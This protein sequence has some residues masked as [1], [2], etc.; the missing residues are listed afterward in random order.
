MAGTM[1]LALPA[2]SRT[3]A[4]WDPNEGARVVIGDR[5]DVA[6]Y[7]SIS[8]LGQGHET[9]MAQICA[10]ALGVPMEWITIFHGNTD[11]TPFGWGTFA[12]RGTVM[13]GSAVHLAGQKLKQKL[14]KAAA[15]QLGADTV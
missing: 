13:Y 11:I 14:L 5:N 4:D 12:S 2:S 7:L 15:E 6:V 10:D 8:V 1:V 9:A 3:P